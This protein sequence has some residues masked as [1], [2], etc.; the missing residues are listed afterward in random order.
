MTKPSLQVPPL[1]PELL[2]QKLRSFSQKKM[3]FVARSWFKDQSSSSPV[4]WL[5][6]ATACW[7]IAIINTHSVS[8]VRNPKELFDMK[9]PTHQESCTIMTKGWPTSWNPIASYTLICIFTGKS[10]PEIEY[11][12]SIHCQF[13]GIHSFLKN[14][15]KKREEF[16]VLCKLASYPS[17]MT[18]FSSI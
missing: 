12:A 2:W 15:M 13:N 9:E 1:K 4:Q 5:D 10:K 17:I 16:L 14:F 6:I 3:I 18:A 8:F 7:P 11:I